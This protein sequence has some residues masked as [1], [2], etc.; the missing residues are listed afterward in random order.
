MSRRFLIVFLKVLGVF[1]WTF[2]I[3]LSLYGDETPSQIEILKKISAASIRHALES[4]QNIDE[5]AARVGVSTSELRRI[6]LALKISLPPSPEKPTPP[7]VSIPA[8]APNGELD[9]DAILAFQEKSSHILIVDKSDH[10]LYLLKYE[11]NRPIIEDVFECK[12]GK[13]MGDKQEPGDHKTPEGIYFFLEKYTRREIVNQVGKENAYQYGALAFVTN[14]PNQID[15]VRG[16]KGGG[17][18]LHGTD[19]PF[20]TTPSLDTRGCVVTT[21]ET[22]EKLSL[23]IK[24]DRTPLIVVDKLNIVPRSEIESER[25]MV[26]SRIEQW[27]NAWSQKRIDDYIIHYSSLFS[28]QGLNLDQWKERKTGLAKINGAIRIS[29]GDF[30]ILKQKDGMI[31]RFTQD[32]GADNVSNIGTKTLYLIQENANWEIVTEHFRKS[33]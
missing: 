33:N 18:W 5:V 30:I 12:T 1:L 11:S 6:C 20:E 21:N 14:F 23:Y 13:N 26:L 19:E 9:T 31:V 25:N 15:R 3:T 2:L 16:K 32:Y 8:F 17:I 22:I 4:T 24:L 27:R 28:S 29:L 10:K 7:P